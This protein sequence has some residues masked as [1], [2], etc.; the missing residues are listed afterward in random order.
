MEDN[1]YYT[2]KVEKERLP[3]E[4]IRTSSGRIIDPKQIWHDG[5]LIKGSPSLMDFSKPEVR[6]DSS[7]TYLYSESTFND[8]ATS[9]PL[10]QHIEGLKLNKVDGTKNVYESLLLVDIIGREFDKDVD[11][12][13]SSWQ[14]VLYD[15]KNNAYAYGIGEPAVDSANGTILFRSEK[16]VDELDHDLYMSFYRYGG[17]KGIFGGQLG[18]DLPIRDDVVHFKSA[19]SDSRTATFKIDGEDGHTIYI[20]PQTTGIYHGPADRSGTI[21]L[22]ENYNEIDWNIGRHNGGHFYDDGRVLKL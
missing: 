1:K 19:S 5:Q 16:F 15:D 10:V 13:A 9:I 17:R 3:E 14:F 2:S 12:A 7:G 8:G 11:E 6:T 18:V 20:L 21:M 22:E 4:E